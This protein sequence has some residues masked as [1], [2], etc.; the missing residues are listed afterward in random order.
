METI[1]MHLGLLPLVFFSF[2][3]LAADGLCLDREQV[4]FSCKTNKS[5]KHLSVCASER[6]D[7]KDSY[8][9]YR[10][11][12]PG[13]IELKFPTEKKNSISQFRYSHYFRY[14]VDRAELSFTIKPFH[15]S[16]FHNYE[17]DSGMPETTQGITVS[18][19]DVPGKETEI[20]CSSPASNHLQKLE[21]IVPCDREN[22]LAS[23]Y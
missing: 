8:V 7:E 18:K 9:Q 16:V 3:A 17:G 15:Y 22:S 6:L 14:L 10:F 5:T 11:G 20:L 13:N 12:K 4:I 21:N 19:S 1:D 2:S 23:C